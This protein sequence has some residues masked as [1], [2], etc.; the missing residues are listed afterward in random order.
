MRKIL[1]LL[2]IALSFIAAAQNGP[3]LAPQSQISII[4]VTVI[5]T[6][7][8]KEARDQTVVMS[9]GKIS[10][11]AKSDDV[12]VPASA[13]IVDG[14]GKYLIPGLWD[15][16]V[17]TWDYESTYP[18]YI[19][20]GVTGVRDMFGP[21]DANK[22]R[23][24]LAAKAILA[25]HFY[26]ASPIVDG[27]PAVWP[28]S[29]EVTTAD[30]AKAVVDDQQHNGADFIKVYSRL[31]R[32]AYFA[33]VAEAVRVGIP[34]EGHVPIQITA[35]EASDN[36]QKSIE[37]LTGIALACS[38]RGKELQARLSPTSTMKERVAIAAEASRSYSE[39]K[40]EDFFG[41][42]KANDTWQVPTLTVLRSFGLVNDAT[43]VQDQRLRYFTKEYRDWLAPKDDFRLKNWTAD[44][45]AV[46]R[47]QFEFSKKLVGEMFHAGV[48]I[49]AGTDTG[50]PY[51]FPGFSLHDELALL[52][53]S[54]VTP[55]AAL[56]AATRNAAVFMKRHG[57]LRF[58]SEGK[59]CGLGFARCRSAR[60]HS[61][62]NQNLG[63]ILRGQGIRQGGTR[64]D[65]EG[66]GDSG[67]H[68]GSISS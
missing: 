33:I 61:Q 54:G 3:T 17:H 2:P 63:S 38:T 22:F 34:V 67:G 18:L 16:H 37:H 15:M 7:T 14:R 47:E 59:D 51:C 29:L 50:N 36:K 19:A 40:C 32:E 9:D 23:R 57:S 13:R 60:R 25:P 62:H 56:Q 30:Q 65:S 24:E 31:S 5:D 4:H 21:P 58:H 39:T 10:D 28:Q 26:L 43:F 35:W 8:G 66:G 44:D 27:H 42:S 55:L 11:L 52:V 6:D 68:F 20:D 1:S 53:E 45:F 64:S 48:S 41:H 46:E 49:L 12:A